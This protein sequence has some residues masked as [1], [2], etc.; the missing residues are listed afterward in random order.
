MVVATSMNGVA[1]FR[2][3][4]AGLP[5]L[6]RRVDD[7]RPPKASHHHGEADHLAW[8]ERPFAEALRA[9]EER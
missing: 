8:L 1:G 3:H 9:L 6:R 7:D 2:A 5:R 4:L